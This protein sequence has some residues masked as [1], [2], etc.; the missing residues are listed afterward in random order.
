MKDKFKKVN[1]AKIVAKIETAK[2][3]KPQFSTSRVNSFITE[4]S[5]ILASQ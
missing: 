5:K 1:R 4:M 3:I 2:K